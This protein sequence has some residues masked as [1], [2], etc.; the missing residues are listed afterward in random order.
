LLEIEADAIFSELS[1]PRL[2][3]EPT[4]GVKDSVIDEE[5]F[6]QSVIDIYNVKNKRRRL[7][8]I[9]ALMKQIE[10]VVPKLLK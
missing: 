5:G 10:E 3:G 9:M 1:S 8:E 2:K 6:P 4:A 7:E